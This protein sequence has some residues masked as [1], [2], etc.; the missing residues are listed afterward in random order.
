M[1]F[2]GQN[3]SVGAYNILDDITIGSNTNGPFNLLL[4]GAEFKPESANHLLVSLNGVIQ[5]PDSSFTVSGSQITFIPSSGTLNSSD[6]ID[7]IMVLGNVLNVGTPTDGTISENKIATNAVTSNK[8]ASNAV[9]MNKLATS[10]T[11]PALNGSALTGM[12][13]TF[14]GLHSPSQNVTTFDIPLSKTAH[15]YYKLFGFLHNV[16]DS[17]NAYFKFLNDAGTAAVG[18]TGVYHYSRLKVEGGAVSQETNDSHGL[19]VWSPTIGNAAGE[20]GMNF[21]MLVGPT[22]SSSFPIQM[23]GQSFAHDAGSQAS[24]NLFGGGFVT[25]TGGTDGFGGVRLYFSGSSDM[26]SQSFVYVYGL[27]KS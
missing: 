5:K 25:K 24:M 23:Q 11:L 1:P 27:N 7:F 4:N 17:V 16:S 26:T 22:N 3:P 13:M 2:I 10:G 8:I 14:I 15:D 18:G 9:T 12:G 19:I 6:S 20:T 21:E